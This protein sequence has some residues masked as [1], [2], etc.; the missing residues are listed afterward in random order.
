VRQHVNWVL[1]LVIMELYYWWAPEIERFILSFFQDLQAW[2][3]LLNAEKYLET[4]MKCRKDGSF[5]LLGLLLVS[6]SPV[7][8]S[9]FTS[10]LGNEPNDTSNNDK[11]NMAMKMFLH[12]SFIFL[13]IL[14]W[15]CFTPLS[16]KATPPLP[17]L[18]LTGWNF[19]TAV[20]PR[21][22]ILCIWI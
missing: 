1:S 10:F 11:I 8:L 6:L 22:C 12:S 16:P 13:F 9:L 18:L 7:S 15:V 5:Y 4:K 21:I 14:L 17:Y 3:I 2:N 20:P 19:A